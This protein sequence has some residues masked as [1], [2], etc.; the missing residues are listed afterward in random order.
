MRYKLGDVLI[1][2]KVIGLVRGPEQAT[3]V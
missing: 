3:R 2:G 1:Q